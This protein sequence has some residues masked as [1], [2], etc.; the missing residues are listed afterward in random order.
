MASFIGIDLGTT[1]SAVATIDKTGRP[2]IVHNSDGENITPSCVTETEDGVFEV[3]E[4]ARRTWGNA[5]DKAASRFKRDMG[6]SNHQ[7]INSRS[8]SPSEL[9]AFVLKKLLQDAGNEVG[10]I[11]EAVVTIPANFSNEAR[12]ATMAAA[13]S[14]GLDVKYIINEPTAAALY[15]AF[16][17][18]DDLH[19]N[20]AVYDLGG[21]TFDVSV[22][23]VDGQN[24]EVLASNG[25]SRLGG[26]DFDLI[27]KDIITRKYTE[28]TGETLEL[29]DFTTNDAEEEKKS[30]S[31]RKRV[32]V[33]VNRKLIDVSREEFE[34]A[35][36]TQVMQTEML[37]ESTIE[38]ANINPSDIRAVFLAGGSTRIPLVQESIKRVFGQ[39]PVSSVNV[40]EVVALGAALYAAYK[41]DKTH[42]SEVQ[43][44]SI[45]KIKVSETTSKSFGT[46]SIVQDEERQQEKLYN[47]VLIKKGE[48][49]PCSV[50][51]SFFTRHDGQEGVD[52]KLTESTAPETDPRFVKIIWEGALELPAGRP[53]GQEIKVTFSYDEN[54][55]MKCSFVDAATG[56]KTEVDLSMG[57][58]DA[59]SDNQID[60]FMVE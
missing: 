32:T 53:A 27:L 10:N 60:K 49:I 2:V 56:R 45:E 34:E 14:A 15:Y 11:G 54:Q 39:D 9:S 23:R 17:N 43:K 52:C 29:D 20:Y 31:K 42:L 47:S 28:L 51:N 38:E 30:L 55:M 6:T 40:D 37:C 41:G 16:K 21:G 19:G 4:Y 22:I 7:I 18:G 35:I 12:D 50:T 59:N 3:G 46:I 25:V 57:S 13:N 48:K 5:P 33:K 58:G 26:D 36:S 44:N 24:V 8:F 1:F